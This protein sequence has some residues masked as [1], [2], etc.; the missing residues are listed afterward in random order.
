MNEGTIIV[1]L[2]LAQVELILDALFIWRDNIDL[3]LL[4]YDFLQKQVYEQAANELE[5]LL[6]L[7]SEE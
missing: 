7:D 3:P 4:D 1:S 5:E 2:T 6:G